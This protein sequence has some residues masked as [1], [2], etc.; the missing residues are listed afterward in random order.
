MDQVQKVPLQDNKS[1]GSRVA[2]WALLQ[3]KKKKRLVK[4]K[5][6]FKNPFKKL[7]SDKKF[8]LLELESVLQEYFLCSRVRPGIYPGADPPFIL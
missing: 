2:S 6:V 4:L 5:T 8:F 1:Q 3:K 7:F